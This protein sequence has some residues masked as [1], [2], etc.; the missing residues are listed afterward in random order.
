[1]AERCKEENLL[2]ASP[3][4]TMA[5]VKAGLSHDDSEKRKDG[6]DA[7]ASSPNRHA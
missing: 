1:M 6:G 3:R 5:S 7:P 2:A 4:S